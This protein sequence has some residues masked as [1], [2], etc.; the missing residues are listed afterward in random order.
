MNQGV[1]RPIDFVLPEGLVCSARYP[2]PISGMAAAI[3]PAVT[4]CVLGTFIQIVPERCMA[5]PAGIA[6]TVA[7]G[8][9]PRPGFEREFVV[10]IW[11]EGGWGGRP[12]KRDNHV[13]MCIYATSATNQPMEQQERLA[14]MMFDAYRLKDGSFRPAPPPVAPGDTDSRHQPHRD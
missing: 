9:D 11:L 8:Y 7:G 2:A 3:F 14:P 1:F 10:Y 5:G 12:A 6:N 4:D 13:S